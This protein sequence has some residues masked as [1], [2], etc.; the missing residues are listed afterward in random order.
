MQ[1]TNHNYQED[2]IDLKELFNTISENKKFIFIFTSIITLLAITY[3]L[4]KTP[5]YEAR[6]LVEIGSYKLSNNNNNNNNNKI[7]LDNSSELVKKLNLLY[8]DMKKNEKDRVSYISSISTVKKINNFIEIKSEAIS[9]ELAKKEINN[10]VKYM[11]EKHQK[12]LDEV[13]QNKLNQMA[14]LSRKI[15]YLEDTEITSIERK[16]N[17][18]KNIV[19][20]S[21]ENKISLNKKNIKEYKNQLFLTE[22]NLKLISKKDST[23]AAI[24]I[25]EKRNLEEKIN[26]IELENITL[27]EEKNDILLNKLQ[28]LEKQLINLKKYKLKDLYEEKQVLKLSML[29][30]NY[31]N[32]QIVGSIITNDYPTKPKKKLTVIVAFITGL[33]LSVFLVFFLEFIKGS[34]E[35]D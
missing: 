24:N 10:I 12:V 20:K 4:T 1:D 7:S 31:K 22:K 3:V 21:L 33:I 23:L 6:S 16:I 14:K 18:N 11:Q 35:N 32:T 19:L 34:K 9:N 26:T 28:D 8:I 27:K 17:Y 5:I 25:M 2:E 30:I 15:E 29:P 13:T